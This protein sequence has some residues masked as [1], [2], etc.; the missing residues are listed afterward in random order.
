MKYVVKAPDGLELELKDYQIVG[1]VGVPREFAEAYLSGERLIDISF[2]FYEKEGQLYRAE[3]PF[4]ATRK[5]DLSNTVVNGTSKVCF[6]EVTYRTTNKPIP[7]EVDL[8]I[9]IV[10]LIM[11]TGH[12]GTYRHNGPTEAAALSADTV[13]QIHYNNPDSSSN[14]INT[15]VN[16]DHLFNIVDGS[17]VRSNDPVWGSKAGTEIR[18]YQY[19]LSFF[20][21]P[22]DAS[23]PAVLRT[24]SD[25]LVH[26]GIIWLQDPEYKKLIAMSGKTTFN[27][28]EFLFFKDPALS[29]KFFAVPITSKYLVVDTGLVLVE[30]LRRQAKEY[31]HSDWVKFTTKHNIKAARL[32]GYI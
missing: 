4:W 10:K 2:L 7:V 21:V 23:K 20:I 27:G 15:R 9:G 5:K 3:H 19:L 17:R 22:K 29:A 18:T 32:K 13:E 16:L 24:P 12:K 1:G 31:F 26:N 30:A 8:P 14:Q 25:E 6:G 28:K 11:R